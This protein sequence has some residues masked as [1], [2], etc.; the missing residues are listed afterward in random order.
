V[1]KAPD[2]GSS[3]SASVEGA[4]KNGAFREEAAQ[5]WHWV[6]NIAQNPDFADLA[7]QS[8][9]TLLHPG[10]VGSAYSANGTGTLIVGMNPG[11]G[12]DTPNQEERDTLVRI[13][14]EASVE[15]FTA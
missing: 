4:M 9:K 6:A 13:R 3:L 2:Q 12:T 8:T 7:S 14:D 11:G 5:L 1:I 15:A 10:F